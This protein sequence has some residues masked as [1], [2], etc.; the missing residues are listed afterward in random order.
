ML[1]VSFNSWYFTRGTRY[2][3]HVTNSDCDVI[4]PFECFCCDLHIV[5]LLGSTLS[6]EPPSIFFLVEDLFTYWVMPTNYPEVKYA[7]IHICLKDLPQTKRTFYM[8][9]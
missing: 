3:I 2:G 6:N 5:S 9:Q 4:E 8:M 7:Y 1:F